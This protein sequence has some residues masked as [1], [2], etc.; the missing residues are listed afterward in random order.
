M[1]EKWA[2][3]IALL[4]GLMILLLV[5]AFALNQNP[6]ESDDRAATIKQASM[7]ESEHELPE[8]IVVKPERPEQIDA[9]RLVYEQQGCVFCHSIAGAGN[10]R[11]PLDGVGLRRTSEEIRDRIIGAD[12][13]LGVIPERALKFKRS[14]RE[15]NDDD[16]NN[17]IIYLQAQP[18]RLK[19]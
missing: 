5:M 14:Y 7:L 6:V 12:S 10:P 1:R 13:L 16:L 18:A 15:L 3:G 17:L 9:G 19:P 4:T 2:R 11:N 8:P